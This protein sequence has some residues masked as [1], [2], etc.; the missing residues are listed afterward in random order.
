MKESK[1]GFTVLELVVVILF[2][3]LAVVLFFVQKMN[4]DAMN[5]DDTRKTAIN[6]MY[7]S[8]EEGYFAKNGFYPETISEENLTTMDPS[9]FTDPNGINLG[10]DGSSYSYQPANCEDGKCR[11]YTLR[12]VLEKEEDYIKKN[13]SS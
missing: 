1:T 3:S 8:L 6:A 13:R 11:E 9:L 10:S 2:V 7:Y 12:A 5:R 4:I